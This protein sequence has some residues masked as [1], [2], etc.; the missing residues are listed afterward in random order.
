METTPP[1]SRTEVDATR[2]PRVAPSSLYEDFDEE[3]FIYL[4]TGCSAT[5]GAG[6]EHDLQMAIRHGLP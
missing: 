4:Q 5:L 1:A 2:T 3:M 6:T